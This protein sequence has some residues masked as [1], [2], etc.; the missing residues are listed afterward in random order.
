MEIPLLRSLETDV[1]CNECSLKQNNRIK[2]KQKNAKQNRGNYCALMNALSH[3]WR[4]IQ[5]SLVREIKC[6]MQRKH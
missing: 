3:L 1:Y 2:H 6:K 4:G 5:H